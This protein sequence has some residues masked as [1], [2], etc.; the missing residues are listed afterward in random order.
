MKPLAIL[1]EDTIIA[2]AIFIVMAVLANQVGFRDANLFIANMGLVVYL[3][4]R[5]RTH[6]FSG[7]KRWL[8]RVAVIISVV[9]LVSIPLLSRMGQL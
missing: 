2:I 8:L 5:R 9:V 6:Q 4:L 7:F 3:V 1:I